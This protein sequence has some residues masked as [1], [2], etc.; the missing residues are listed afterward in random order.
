MLWALV[1]PELLDALL[2]EAVDQSSCCTSPVLAIILSR[3]H[4]TYGILSL[5]T[6]NDNFFGVFGLPPI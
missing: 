6:E 4:R 2:C 3:L 5:A 1:A